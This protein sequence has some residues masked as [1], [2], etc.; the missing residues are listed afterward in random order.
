MSTTVHQPPELEHDAMMLRRFKTKLGPRQ[1]LERRIVWNLA[2]HLQA[3]GFKI[4]ALNDGE[5]VV[6]LADDAK[7]LMELVFNLDDSWPIFKKPGFS[8]KWVAIVLGNGID[9]IC[10]N[11][12]Q[13]GDADGFAAAMDA[14]DVEEFA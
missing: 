14:F 7:A 6:T 2:L 5:E 11:S 10:D 1:R 8:R 12:Y 4:V 3:A 13:E 9:C